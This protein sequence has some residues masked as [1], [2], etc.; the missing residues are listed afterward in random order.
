MRTIGYI[1]KKLPEDVEVD[2]RFTRVHRTEGANFSFLEALRYWTDIA[3]QRLPPASISLLGIGGGKLSG[4]EYRLALVLGAR[5]GI[6]AESIGTGTKLLQSPEWQELDIQ[7]IEKSP[8][9]VA[10]F[11]ANG[12]TLERV[13]EY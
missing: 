8:N 2:L 10:D 12:T 3:L 7:I 9:A 5:V 6:L 13:P 11:L 4:L 1:P